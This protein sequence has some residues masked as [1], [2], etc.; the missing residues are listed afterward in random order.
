MKDIESMFA[1]V[2]SR[3]K[4]LLRENR[5]L[6]A[7]IKELEQELESARRELRE[8]HHFQGKKIHI[9]EKVEK[10]LSVLEEAGKGV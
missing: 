4:K 10:I 2:E 5:E 7:R 3:V 1:E 9:R 8:L 6:K